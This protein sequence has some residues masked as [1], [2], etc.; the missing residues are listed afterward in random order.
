MKA[1]SAGLGAVT[2]S[3]IVKQAEEITAGGRYRGNSSYMAEAFF[4]GLLLEISGRRGQDGA[5]GEIAPLQL[6]SM[7][8]EPT[9]DRSVAVSAESAVDKPLTRSAASQDDSR[10]L[11][12]VSS[13][14]TAPVAPA[15]ESQVLSEPAAAGNES[16]LSSGD[17]PA[18]LWDQILQ[19]VKK[20]KI[21]LHAFLLASV[22]QEWN[23]GKLTIYFDPVKGDFHKTRSQ[24]GDNLQVIMETAEEVLGASAK[25][26]CAF[27]NG[28]QEKDPVDMAIEI[29]GRDVVKLV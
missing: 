1:Q 10:A 11:R 23:E 5:L 9:A 18:G 13:E 14:E 17:L 20:R 19:I 7:R 25:V 12:S 24:E 26:E 16:G 22:K 27:A 21:V 4:A 3:R 15:P 28:K 8:T 6:T 2:L 29:F